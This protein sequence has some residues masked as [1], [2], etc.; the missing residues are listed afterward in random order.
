MLGARLNTLHNLWFYQ[1]LMRDI[2]LAIEEGR[3]AAFAEG[4]RARFLA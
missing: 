3:F 1:D 4:F 2:R